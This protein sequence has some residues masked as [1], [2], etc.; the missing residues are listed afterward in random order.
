MRNE[1][2]FYFS[3]YGEDRIISGVFYLNSKG[4]SL[5]L[6]VCIKIQNHK[7]ANGRNVSISYWYITELSITV[8]SIFTENLSE[9][10][11]V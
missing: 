11:Y 4:C 9:N 7:K 3:K 8:K 2:Y 10:S 5:G 6:L 1:A